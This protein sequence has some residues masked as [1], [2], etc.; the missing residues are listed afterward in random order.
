[1]NTKNMTIDGELDTMGS[2]GSP[3]LALNVLNNN[4]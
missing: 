3:K 2:L 4:K 1:M